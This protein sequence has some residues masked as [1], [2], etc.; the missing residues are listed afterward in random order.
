MPLFDLFWSIL[1]LFLWF[2]WIWLVVMVVFDIF[3]SDDLS[4]WAKAL[5][6]LFV[7]VIPW[8]GVLVYLIARGDSMGRRRLEEMAAREQATRRYIQTV[9]TTAGASTADELAKLAELR[10]S[11]VITEEEFTA[12][13]A[14]I[15]ATA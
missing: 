13:K 9:A 3:R 12:Q 15:L 8:L 5:W 14:K 6:A 10:N 1:W 7:I 11:G 2:A 4:G